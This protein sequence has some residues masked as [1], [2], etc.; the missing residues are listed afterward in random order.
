MTS[1][2]NHLAT[3]REMDEE[4]PKEKFTVKK[5]A[6]VDVIE[7]T[8]KEKKE[9]T[10]ALALVKW[11]STI[12]IFAA[13]LTCLVGSKLTLISISQNLNSS[14]HEITDTSDL[15]DIAF[16]MI[17]LIMVIPNVISFIRMLIISAFSS[18]DMWPSKKSFFF[19]SIHTSSYMLLYKETC[20]NETTVTNLLN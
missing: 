2:H 4:I 1:S 10:V 18:V 7:D 15:P 8:Q 13:V 6:K 9:T 11:I 3:F 12:I 5:L 20:L 16:V 17:I 19:V 14:D